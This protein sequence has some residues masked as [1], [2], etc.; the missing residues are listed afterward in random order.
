MCDI[1]SH[2]NAKILSLDTP[3]FV[4]VK[5]D[6]TFELKNLPDGKYKIEVF[7]PNCNKIVDE[8]A[9]SDGEIFKTEYD[10]FIKP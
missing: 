7:H 1:H 9:L 6:G 8:I 5:A 10:F 3:Y 2:M 4:R